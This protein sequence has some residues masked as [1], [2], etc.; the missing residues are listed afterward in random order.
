MYP[1]RTVLNYSAKFNVVKETFRKQ[2]IPPKISLQNKPVGSMAEGRV[3]VV[4]PLLKK[5]SGFPRQSEQMSLK[6][7]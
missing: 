6:P 4:L 2:L 7:W 3:S 1:I 5:K